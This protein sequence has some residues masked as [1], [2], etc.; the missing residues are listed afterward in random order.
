MPIPRRPRLRRTDPR[1]LRRG[2]ARLRGR[3]GTR[4]RLRRRSSGWLVGCGF[5]GAGWLVGCG[6]DRAGVGSLGAGSTAPGGSLGA[7]SAVAAPGAAGAAG[8][9]AAAGAASGSRVAGSAVPGQ[10][11][12]PETAAAARRS[13]ATAV[14]AWRTDGQPYALARALVAFAEAL[15]AVGDRAAAGEA[16][17]EAGALAAD[18]DARPLRDE[19]AR[20]ARRVGLRGA[21][22]AGPDVLTAREREVLRLVAVGHSNSRIA[23]ELY[24]SPKTVSVHVSRIIAKL[25]VTNRIEAAAV[26]HR[27]GLL[28]ADMIAGGQT[29]ASGP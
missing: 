21:V 5:G 25:E 20:L 8:V 11:G 10:R 9:G 4:G 23:T 27:L 28:G 6:F 1:Q 29:P 26:A 22:G 18:L 16:L 17:E 14:E 7:G 15:A 3:G 19:V 2:P 13:W 24:L 12:A